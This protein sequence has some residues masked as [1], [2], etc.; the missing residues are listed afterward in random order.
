M[1]WRSDEES[2]LFSFTKIS[3]ANRWYVSVIST[4]ITFYVE[5]H[6]NFDSMK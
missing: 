5:S 3:G 2:G 6:T 4:M 1:L